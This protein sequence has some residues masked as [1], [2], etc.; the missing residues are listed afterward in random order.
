MS[1]N[2]DRLR[3]M[4]EAFN[5]RNFDDAL[6]YL[7]PA[8]AVY[9]GL[10]EPDVNRSYHGRAEVKQLWETIT[11]VWETLLVA[12]EETIEAPGDRVAV[13]ERWRARGRQGIEIDFQLTDVYTFRDGVIVRIEGFTNKTEGLEAAGLSKQDVHAD[14]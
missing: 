3:A 9:P 1:Q 11:E 4:Q 7:H 2:V 10:P 6:R 14:S 5:R 12:F 13:V 8:V